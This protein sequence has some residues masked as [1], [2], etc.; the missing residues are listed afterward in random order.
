M[1]VSL[2]EETCTRN[3]ENTGEKEGRV[4][5]LNAHFTGSRRQ[6]IRAASHTS[7]ET[8]LELGKSCAGLKTRGGRG[9]AA[10]VFG[11]TTGLWYFLCLTANNN[12]SSSSG[13]ER[14]PAA[15]TAGAYLVQVSAPPGREAA[16]KSLVSV[17]VFSLYPSCLSVL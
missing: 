14:G 16:T 10:S 5:T 1:R 11:G 2:A 13:G 15:N 9:E 8:H 6:L 12:F 7:T 17:S 3:P 4:N